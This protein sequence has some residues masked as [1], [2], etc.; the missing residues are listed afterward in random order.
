MNRALQQTA[1]PPADRFSAA[2]GGMRT[3][4]KGRSRLIV[5][6]AVLFLYDVRIEK[7]AGTC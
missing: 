1:A 7:R 3:A 2:R 5:P 6:G 4:K